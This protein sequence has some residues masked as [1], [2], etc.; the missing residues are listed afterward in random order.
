MSF[1]SHVCNRGFSF[2]ILGN[3]TI[4]HQK[5][6]NIGLQE[7]GIIG[8]LHVASIFIFGKFSNLVFLMVCKVHSGTVVEKLR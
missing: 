7:S 2:G 3:M 4:A 5:F 1:L 6:F 8:S